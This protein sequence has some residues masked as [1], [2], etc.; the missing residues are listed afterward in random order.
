[1]VTRQGAQ[2][3]Q[4]LVPGGS[5]MNTT[6][7]ASRR[8]PGTL[9]RIS[10]IAGIIAVI[11]LAVTGPGYRLRI[12]PLL[13]AL[14]ATA[15]GFLLF[16]LSFVLGV[17]GLLAGGGRLVKSRPMM[18]V[19]AVSFIFTIVFAISIGRARG[20]PAIHDI[21]TDLEDP[22]AFKDAIPL[23]AAADALN[24]PEYQR[25]GK[26]GSQEINVPEAQR[27][28]YP[29]VQP[30]VLPQPPAEATQLAHDVARDLGWDIISVVPSEGRVEATDTTFYFGFKDDV[31]VRVRSEST[32]SRIDVRSESRVGGGDIGTNAKRVRAFL[33]ALRKKS[34]Q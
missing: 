34:G 8:W 17:I 23:R 32:G 18:L 29:D 27:A 11:L 14:A 20:I 28:A 24:P 25:V 33:A 30:L 16:V 12:L 19:L 21:T 6:V 2:F 13:P 3:Q 26:L 1:M 15:L 7:V 22:P 4:E 9:L 5:P 31:V 10:F